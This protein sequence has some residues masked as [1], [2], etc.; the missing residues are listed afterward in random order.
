MLTSDVLAPG[1]MQHDDLV[2]H[3]G[4]RTGRGLTRNQVPRKTLEVLQP[5]RR[6]CY[7]FDSSAVKAAE[8]DSL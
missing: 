8:K 6:L 1:Q 4:V 5:Q 7:F 3:V 2:V